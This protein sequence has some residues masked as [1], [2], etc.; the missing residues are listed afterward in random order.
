[1]ALFVRSSCIIIAMIVI[2]FTSSVTLTFFALLLL[3]PSIV[4]NRVFMAFTQKYNE[5]YQD[6]KGDLGS[7]ATEVISNV[8]TVKAFANEQYS[9]QQY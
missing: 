5:E 6:A 3:I 1:M 8:R 4:S 7:I 2:M 9:I